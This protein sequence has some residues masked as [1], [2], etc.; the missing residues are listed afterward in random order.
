MKTFLEI[1]SCDFD[2]LSYLSQHGWKGVILEPIPEYYNNLQ[3]EKNIQYF[4]VA[5]YESDGRVMMTTPIDELKELDSDFRGMSTI[6]GTM[7]P[8]RYE[9]TQIKVDTMCFDTLFKLTNITELDYLKIDVEGYDGEVLKMFPWDKVKPKYIKFESEHLKSMG[10]LGESITL[11]KS[12]GYHVE[13]DDRN[14]YAI[15]L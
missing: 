1:G 9:S 7:G 14:T 12:H 11:L 13:I 3:F 8:C 2:T 4:N 15:L 10:I 6:L 5:I